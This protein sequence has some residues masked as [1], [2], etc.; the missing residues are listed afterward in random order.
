M[1]CQADKDGSDTTEAD[2]LVS[3]YRFSWD[4][5]GVWMFTCKRNSFSWMNLK[6]T[7]FLSVLSETSYPEY[8]IK[9][10]LTSEKSKM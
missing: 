1:F 5:I 6:L 3:V 4:F 7:Q 9:E 8:D 10:P 2:Q